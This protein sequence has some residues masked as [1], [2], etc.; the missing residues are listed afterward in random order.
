MGYSWK[1]EVKVFG[2]GG[3]HTNA[4]RFKT[5]KEAEAYAKD[6]RSR[7][8]LVDEWRVK[9]CKDPVNYRWEGGTATPIEST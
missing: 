2:E 6:L 9:R 3:Y 5:K 4:L 7:W 1:A 8:T